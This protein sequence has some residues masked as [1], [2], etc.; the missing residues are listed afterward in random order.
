MSPDQRRADRAEPMRMLPLPDVADEAEPLTEMVD[1]ARAQLKPLLAIRPDLKFV[2][3][4]RVPDA[5]RERMTV[6]LR[7]ARSF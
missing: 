5:R 2:V 3:N 1:L 6:G 4:G 7:F